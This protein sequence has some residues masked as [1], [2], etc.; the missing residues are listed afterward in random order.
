[1]L[2]L[3]SLELGG[4]IL[5]D[6]TIQ[7]NIT[8]GSIDSLSY[9]N[10]DV[11]VNLNRFEV[12]AFLQAPVLSL[13]LP[14][15]LPAVGVGSTE[16]IVFSI[17]NGSFDLNFFV[18]L[19]SPVDVLS[20]FSGGS[21]PVSLDYGGVLDARLPLEVG[22]AGSSIGVELALYDDNLFSDPLPT[23]SYE[24][25][26]CSVVNVTKTLVQELKNQILAVIQQPLQ[27]L[28]VPINLD[29]ITDPLIEKVDSV[30]G[31][32]TD[33][34]E[35]SLDATN[36]GG[37]ENLS[38]LLQET[39]NSSFAS[40][41][42][43]A[44]S[45]VNEALVSVGIVFTAEVSPYFV[46]ETMT[47]GIS[48]T[49]TVSVEQTAA[50][51][52]GLVEDFFADAT[53]SSGVS[54]LGIDNSDAAAGAS[55]DLNALLDDTVISVGVDVTFA[56]ELDLK[57]IQ[58]V[59]TS[60]TPVDEALEEGIGLHITT[61]GAYASLIVDPIN[62][63]LTLFGQTLGIRNSAIA[64]SAGLRSKGAFF[65]SAKD[66][67]DGT[68]DTSSL[69]PDLTV[70][71]SAEV[72]FDF[73]VPGV[74]GVTISPI[75]KLDSTNLLDD[76]SIDFDVDLETFLSEGLFGDNR[77]DIVLDNVTELLGTIASKLCIF[78]LL[79]SCAHI[80]SSTYHFPS[81]RITAFSPDLQVGS[82]PSAVSGFF[83]IIDEFKDFAG[84][85]T[86][87]TDLFNEVNALV[88]S[89]IRS[90]VRQASR[91]STDGGCVEAS[92]TF[93]T[94]AYDLL[95][96]EGLLNVS[97]TLST[98]RVCEYLPQL[99]KALNYSVTASSSVSYLDLVVIPSALNTTLQSYFGEELDFGGSFVSIAMCQVHI[100]LDVFSIAILT[101]SPFFYNSQL[102]ENFGILST[103]RLMNFIH[104]FLLSSG[105]GET[106]GR[107][108]K[109]STERSQV[110]K[111]GSVMRAVRNSMLPLVESPNP[112]R[113]LQTTQDEP[114]FE[115]ELNDLLSIY[116][117][118]NIGD[119]Q[120]TLMLGLNFH[121]FSDESAVDDITGE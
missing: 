89:E 31:N 3:E 114:L 41:F 69:I 4:N 34:I 32:F 104:K 13:D 118:F 80:I 27:N 66:I 28:D 93:S 43:D 117:D 51:I 50:D 65:A 109:S 19:T 116:L 29:K 15:T 86:N 33:E 22:L 24:I 35:H 106:A 71:L 11:V 70:P 5:V 59:I 53:N 54:Y 62:L 82:T 84:A 46:S 121:F 38:R 30:L 99:Q 92:T 63:E 110:T 73:D 78:R 37:T 119:G 98:F 58:S 7:A 6:L 90:V 36:C 18:N 103:R 47:A 91:L 87:F 42:R 77:L 2:V 101:A 25:D 67:L 12:V 85:L 113:R 74:D 64:L 75:L 115:L 40:K 57:E 97:T 72:V 56:I 81:L 17:F 79:K 100:W 23:L 21:D 108:L 96:S 48:T 105:D 1:M 45:S 120:K 39:T 107:R 68:A 26:V 83:Q 8:T 94:Y 9:D 60:G 88:P 49:L 55:L 14:L 20:L 111:R 61:W 95:E 52:I 16:E 102:L 76:F 44:I 112:S 10:V